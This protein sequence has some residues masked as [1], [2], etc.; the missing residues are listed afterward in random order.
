MLAGE[1]GKGGR[2]I[3]GD[4]K[5]TLQE[6]EEFMSQISFTK[7]PKVTKK[8]LGKYLGAF[9]QKQIPGKEAPK[10]NRSQVNFLMDGR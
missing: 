6:I 10:A 3:R 8:D 7:G 1:Y 9:P 2:M 5:I 4:E